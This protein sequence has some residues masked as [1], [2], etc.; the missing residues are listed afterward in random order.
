MLWAAVAYAALIG[1]LTLPNPHRL[2]THLLG[3]NIDNWIFY[4]NNWRLQ[5]AI[6][7]KQ[8]WFFSNVTFF[9]QGI[10]LVEHSNSFLNSLLAFP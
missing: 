10:S 1:A 8:S 2:F 6:T 4:W 5:Q 7:T 3:N 9:P